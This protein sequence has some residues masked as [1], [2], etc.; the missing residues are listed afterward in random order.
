MKFKQINPR[1]SKDL[2]AEY[3][4]LEGWLERNQTKL[5]FLAAKGV[6]TDDPE[7]ITLQEQR[8][9]KM[10]RYLELGKVIYNG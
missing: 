8:G 10:K 2:V 1:P 5:K 4:A 3:K 9:Q 7:W 6:K